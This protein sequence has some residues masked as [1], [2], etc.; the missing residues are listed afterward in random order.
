MA[1]SGSGSVPGQLSMAFASGVVGAGVLVVVA[2]LMGRFGIF[3]DLGCHL[4]PSAN[5]EYLY[6]RLVWG[7]IFGLLFCLPIMSGSVWKRG[8]VFGLIPAA[9]QLLVIFPLLNHVQ[10]LGLNYGYT[11]PIFVVFLNAVWGLTSAGWLKMI[12]G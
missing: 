2:L 12:G 4:H 3:A 9:V 7:G 6:S 10:V 5:R 8:F 1:A 11:T